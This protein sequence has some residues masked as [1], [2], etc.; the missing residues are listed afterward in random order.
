TAA[1]HSPAQL[2]DLADVPVLGSLLAWLQESFDVSLGDLQNAVTQGAHTALQHFASIGRKIFLGA[3][4]TVIGFIITIFLLF[5]AVRDGE[6][7]L[8]A[9]RALIPM[10][11]E[12]KQRLL[13][14]L[15]GVARAV[16]YV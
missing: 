7:I 3:V 14:Y 2:S 11:R 13:G 4:G 10:R 5:F 15:G 9:L 12:H 1:E 8:D 16:F 6:R